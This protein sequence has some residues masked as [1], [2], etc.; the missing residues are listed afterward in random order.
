MPDR[1]TE[2]DDGGPAFPA[3]ALD[4]PFA[5][6]GNPKHKGMSLLDYFAGEAM[7]GALSNPFVAKK[8]W[9]VKTGVDDAYARGAYSIADAMLQERKR[10]QS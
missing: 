6:A 3:N 1:T 7:K 4:V 9:D 2:F 8:M 5:D 10:R